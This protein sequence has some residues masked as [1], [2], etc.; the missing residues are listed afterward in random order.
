[1]NYHMSSQQ[2][3]MFSIASGISKG[4]YNID[5]IYCMH[6][7][8]F[9]VYRDGYW[10]QVFDIEL[11]G[12]ICEHR[13]VIDAGIQNHPSSTKKQIL[14]NLKPLVRRSMFDFNIKGWLNFPNGM[15]NV[16]GNEFLPHDKNNISTIRLPYK[17]EPSARCELWI[18]TLMEIFENN[19]NKIDVLQEFFGYCLTR[20]T[21]QIKALLLIGDSKSGKSTILHVLR[22]MIGFKN[23]SSVPMKFISNPQYTPLLINKLV[24]ID[25]DVSERAQDFE[26]EFKIIT[27]GE[28]VNCN[29]KFVPTFE[30][31]P[32]C[33]IVMAANKFPRI[34]DHSSAFYNR[35]VVIPCDRV[36]LPTEQDR[37]LKVRLLEE[38]PG[39]LQWAM[40]GFKRLTQRGMF[41]EKEF[42]IQALEELRDESNPIDVFFRE[43]IETD[44]SGGYEIEKQDLYNKYRAWCN[45]NGNAPM[46]NN[47][48]GSTVYQ[49]YSK[50]TPKTTSNVVTH[51]RVWKNLKY[52]TATIET[53][54]ETISWQQ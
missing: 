15:L 53:P 45:V 51:K 34:T 7:D 38:L 39:I 3:I 29:Q 40:N 31:V 30:F 2:N 18:K 27:S 1:M 12:L 6:E 41:E 33:K 26:F 43:H 54:K 32:Y 9:Y 23:C 37:T 44:V 14:E 49:K 22:H 25:A 20:D 5:S 50:Y 16:E 17:Y 42:I 4:I 10:E 48:F 24:N 8:I 52:T 11:L 47:K 19:S 21:S 13:D 28:P 46:A 35:L 36:F